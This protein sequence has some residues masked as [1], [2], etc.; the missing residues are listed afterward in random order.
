MNSPLLHAIEATPYSANYGF[1]PS[2]DV[3]RVGLAEEATLGTALLPHVCCST[4]SAV[5]VSSP[6]SLW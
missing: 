2:I 4:V 5:T 3:H 6:A 1:I